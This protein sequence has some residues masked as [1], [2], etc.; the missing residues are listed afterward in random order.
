M[1]TEPNCTHCLFFKPQ[2]AE[3]GSTVTPGGICRFLPPAP[4]LDDEGSICS[5]QPFVTDQDYCGQFKASQ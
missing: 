1:I 5:S 2:D 4:M 3:E